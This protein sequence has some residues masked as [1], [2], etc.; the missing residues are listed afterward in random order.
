MWIY[1]L[2]SLIQMKNLN[3]ESNLI[4]DFMKKI[5]PLVFATFIS[6]GLFA[7]STFE[8]VKAIFQANCTVGCHSGGTPAGQLN[9]TGTNSEVYDELINVA[10][11]NPVAISKGFKMVD[12]GYPERSFL[13]IKIS[14]DIDPHT[15]LTLPM[16]N[17]MPD[18]QPALDYDEIE[19]VRQWILYGASD[20][21]TYVD[22]QVLTDYYG[23]LGLPRV[24]PLA[25][26]DSSEGFQI[27]YGPFFLPQLFEKEFFYKYD[28]KLPET[29][30]VYRIET[31]IND[32]GHHTALYKYFTQADSHFAPG[33]RPVSNILDAAGV[34]YTSDIIGQW[35]NS[36][37]LVLPEGAA[38]TWEQGSVVDLNYH[39]LNYNSDSILAAEFYMNVYTQPEGIALAEMKSAPIYYGG[40]NPTV[41]QIPGDA[42]DHT[43]IIEQYDTT[44]TDTWH[45]WSMMA[46]THK[47][48]KG[49]DVWLRNTDGTKGEHIYNGNY[50][51]EYVFDQGYFDWQHPPFRTFEPLLEV[52][53]SVGMIHEAVF[54]NPG[55]NT[56]GFG[57]TNDDEMYVTYI[58]YTDIPLNTSIEENEFGFEY[59]TTYPNPTND[60]LNIAFSS[61]EAIDG[62]L[63]VL[64][65]LG[66]IVFAKKL[67]IIYGKQQLGISKQLLGLSAGLYTVSVTTPYGNNIS[68]VVF[69]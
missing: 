30:E 23:G 13:F 58:Q 51:E 20:T 47:L 25:P 54:N 2:A 9:L 69:E 50:D 7:Q 67:D 1:Y 10:P 46:H 29:K 42:Q 37:N 40:E 12:P 3:L 52:D 65:N 35:P 18:G 48:G 45:L 6:T 5:Y 68:K 17:P 49:F 21:A 36:Q 61:T 41:L 66:R 62:E 19:L 22:P 33:L 63:K 24:T 34:Y 8:Q 11:I 57:L 15:Y 28:T 56:V 38:F 60:V 55:P 16:G 14:H 32:E 64:D 4:E 53:L 26:P 31:S 43:Y 59:F 44:S 27:H 39:I